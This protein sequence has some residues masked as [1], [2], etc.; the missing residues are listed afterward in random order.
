MVDPTPVYLDNG[1]PATVGTCPVCGGKLFKMG[2]TEAHASIAKPTPTAKPAAKATKSAAKKSATTG[3]TATAKTAKTAAK[4]SATTSK[5]AAAK[6]GKTTDKPAATKTAA[7]ASA[8]KT[9]KTTT[10]GKASK[11][12]KATTSAKSTKS[13]KSSAPVKR[14]GSLVIVESPAKAKSVGR[15]LGAGYTVK[16]SKGHV[17]DLYKS[18]LSVDLENNF[19]PTY[20]VPIDKKAT[21]SELKKAAEAAEQI[22][23]ATDPDREGEAIAWHLIHAAGMDEHRIKRVVFHEITEPAVKEAFAHPREVDMSLVNAQQARRILDRIVGYQV[24]ELLWTKVRGR[25]SAGRVQS[26]ALR[27]VVDREREI[28]AF[29]PRE[30][31]T[32]DVDLK[33]QLGEQ[34]PFRARLAKVKGETPELDSEAAVKPHLD[35]LERSL[36]TVSDV[37]KGQMQRKPAAPFTTSTLQQ[38]ASRR[39]GFN[40]RRTM[41]AA[42]QLYEGID[43]GAQGT[44]GLITYMRTDSVNVSAQAQTEART[45]VEKR[46]GKSFIP[47]KPNVYKTKAK[48]AQEAHEAVR[49]TSV[50]RTPDRLKSALSGDQFKLYKLIWE[51]FVASQMSNAVYDTLKIEIEAGPTPKD[52]PYLLRASNRQLAFAG[53]LA[54]YEEGKDDEASDGDEGRIIPPLQANEKLD[55]VRLAP[56]QHFTEP[57]PRYTEA[58]LVKALE[59]F[60]IGRPSTYAPTMGVIQDRDYVEVVNKRMVPTDIG[61]L[62]NDLLVQFFPDFMDFSFT[63]RM[64]DQLDDV[65]EGEAEWQPILGSFYDRFAQQLQTAKADMPR[66]QPIEKI[67]RTCPTCGTGDLIIKH[68]RYGK[69]I[70]CSNYPECKHT[71]PYVER[72]GV[73]CAKCGATDSGELLARK[74]RAGRT[75]FGC[76]RYPDCD[77]TAWRLPKPVKGGVLIIEDDESTPTQGQPS[78]RKTG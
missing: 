66:V 22:F 52:K 55:L 20:T 29:T 47:S 14:S 46:F 56:E 71:E 53:F 32:V 27:L 60:G 67:G 63:A 75:F 12:S 69:F 6:T 72:T 73:M 17:R 48:G 59:E 77:Y 43:L 7:K 41:S 31:W 23:L 1:S 18:K 13:S 30:Y 39:L 50:E 40:A 33:K 68:G 62:V 38:E 45:Y 35:A 24:S 51:R 57:P 19:A 36:Y 58:T 4:K 44:L 64:E 37:N 11:T 28:E 21:V 2:L 34:R 70:G 74:T 26:I 76:S 10:T 54:V 49:P 16:A 15:Y 8:S 78:R 42:Q 3:K 61:K 5:T 9:S 65:A 25:L